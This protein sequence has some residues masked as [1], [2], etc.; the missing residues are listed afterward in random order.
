[1]DSISHVCCFW[2]ETCFMFGF[3][4]PLV[5]GFLNL[6]WHCGLT[7]WLHG[8]F[9]MFDGVYPNTLYRTVVALGILD[10][11]PNSQCSVNISQICGSSWRRYLSSRI[12]VS[13]L[14][15]K[16]TKV[17][18]SWWLR[19]NNLTESISIAWVCDFKGFGTTA[20]RPLTL[21]L[22]NFHHLPVLQPC[23]F[24][25]LGPL[26]LRWQLHQM[27]GA[28]SGGGVRLERMWKI[29]CMQCLGP[30]AK[31]LKTLKRKC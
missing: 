16:Q 2:L 1:M 27:L 22:R 10:P 17:G 31:N 7:T 18:R 6:G 30:H 13:D 24:I 25:A 23:V 4:G 20:C 8:G 12:L 19:K 29:W 14:T 26:P 15:F 21:L 5:P 11:H 3:I 9:V 28:C